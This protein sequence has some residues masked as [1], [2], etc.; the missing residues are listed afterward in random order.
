MLRD[1]NIQ[2]MVRQQ[3][4]AIKPT[5]T[6][7]DLF[8]SR[9]YAAHVQSLVDTSTGRYDLPVK[10]VLRHEDPNATA[11][12]DGRQIH[13]DTRTQLAYGF[14]DLYNKYMANVGMTL[15]E[16]AH[17][18]YCDF[19]A[20]EKCLAMLK[21]GLFYGREPAP[22]TQRGMDALAD[23]KAAMEQEAYGPIFQ[24]ACH[25]IWNCLIDPHDED[26]LIMQYGGFIE[27]AITVLREGLWM[28]AMPIESAMELQAEAKISKLEVMY[29][30]ILEFAR[31]GVVV[32][33]D[34]ET[35]MRTEIGQALTA[36]SK[37]VM[38]GRYTDD[39]LERAGCVNHIMLALW[40]WIREELDRQE[41]KASKDEQ[42]GKD[43]SNGPSASGTPKQE[44]VQE[45]L[46]QLQS[47]AN[48]SGGTQAPKNRCTSKVA[49]D[50]GKRA[51]DSGRKPR[52]AR[53]DPQ[54]ET[55]EGS[56]SLDKL[57][58][59][60]SKQAA[61][62]TVQDGVT[63][64]TCT[65]IYAVDQ[66]SSHKGIPM[67]VLPQND[68]SDADKARYQEVIK[69]VAGY[70]KRLQR[71]MIAALRDLRDGEV[72]HH[73]IAGNRF[74]ATAAYRP[75]ERFFAKKSSPKDLPDMAISLLVDHSGSM[76]GE[77]IQAAMQAAILL[78]DF[79]T[80]LNIPVCV[81]G[82]ATK[83]ERV[84][85]YTYTDYQQVSPSEKYRLAK[86]TATGSN[87]DGF[88]IEIAASLLV[89][90][91]EEV[92]LLIILSDGQPNHNGYGGEAAAEDIQGIVKRY[93]RQGVEVIAAAIGGDKE[94]IK[95]IYGERSYLDITDLAHLPQTL[96]KLVRKRIINQ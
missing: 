78:H 8:Q 51:K 69:E 49:K 40:P 10:V 23:M 14:E 7:D 81:A 95:V 73:R 20:H 21:Q 84:C 27:Q 12:T 91:P 70:S 44:A 36:I 93:K 79:A 24:S 63:D 80:A 67:E 86:M 11:Y 28:G 25:E 72:A 26:A 17:I 83:G 55:K 37:D 82:H 60:I 54:A 35:V 31:F 53:K 22:E 43:G 41:K 50:R 29:K 6:A 48:G 38:L 46:R 61:T 19:D 34:V 66:A 71:R 96:A 68:V 88:A 75:D 15:H 58:N 87:R 2:R 45:I 85:Y 90:R 16:C 62:E 47:G 65:E 94:K 13:Q 1:R 74:E 52:E 39:S 3:A 4:A 76:H 56:A 89:K 5:L 18:L 77:R 32:S 42:N 9:E 64:Q 57:L 59:E 92:K 33:N 30:A